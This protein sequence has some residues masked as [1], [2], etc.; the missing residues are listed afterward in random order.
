MKKELFN[1]VKI[2]NKANLDFEKD[3]FK[4]VALNNVIKSKFIFIESLCHN[5]KFINSPFKD[6][7]LNYL[8][9]AE[10]IYPGAS[11][12]LSSLFCFKFLNETDESYN[13]IKISKNYDKVLNSIKNKS[14]KNTF[15]LFKNIIEFSGADANIEFKT[16]KENNI[17]IIKNKDCIFNINIHNSLNLLFNKDK[18]N[19][20]FLTLIADAFIERE[21]EL[22]PLLEHANKLKFP[23]VFICRGI[24]DHAIKSLKNIM[25]KN[26]IQIFVYTCKFNNEDPFFYKDLSDA[27]GL[28][29]LSKEKE[30]SLYHDYVYLSSIKKLELFKD[31]ILIKDFDKT[32]I[33]ME[34]S[35]QIK[36]NINNNDLL[37]Y[38]YKRKK[39]L[40]INNVTVFIPE[41]QLSLLK[42]LKNLVISFNKSSISGVYEIN[43]NK[44]ESV[45]KLKNINSLC[46]SLYNNINNIGYVIK[47][48]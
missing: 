2:L 21:S 8:K 40:S 38:L 48:Q 17:K 5:E 19:N 11:Y 6:I 12:D 26:N 23:V 41:N 18:I 30:H 9:Q 3:K 13:K 15:N 28:E 35:K 20:E 37:N 31:K 39:R 47:R 33:Q 7:V 10:N 42:D 46:N 44:T 4:V 27:L 14:C 45:F 29:I 43:D 24:T 36:D 1:L 16:T 34:L 32:N 22:I 25:L